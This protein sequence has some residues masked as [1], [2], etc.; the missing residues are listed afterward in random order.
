[1]RFANV[2]FCALAVSIFLS[3]CSKITAV[4]GFSSLVPNGLRVAAVGD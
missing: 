3:F 1:V 4:V 2:L